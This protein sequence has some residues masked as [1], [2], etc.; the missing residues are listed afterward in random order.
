MSVQGVIR[1]PLHWG[2]GL[3]LW[4]L[5]GS[6]E[7][8]QATYCP[9]STPPVPDHKLEVAIKFSPPFVMGS[10]D[11]PEGLS[12]KLWE[13]IANCLN[14]EAKDYELREYGSVDELLDATENG[15]ADLAVA[16]ITATVE[17]EQKVDFSH[18][19]Y[20]AS[21]GALVAKG[22]D[23]GDFPELAK[24]IL[25]SNLVWV[26]L[27]FAALLLAVAGYYWASEREKGNEI[28]IKG[29][30]KG[31]Y[32]ALIWAFLLVFKGQGNPLE[33]H[34]RL[35]QILN[36]ALITLS[37]TIVSSFTAVIT[38]NLTLQGL[39][40]KIT[41]LDDLRNRSVAT[42]YQSPS[43]DWLEQHGVFARQLQTLPQIQEQLDTGGINVFVH[44][45][46]ILQYM[47]NR[48]DLYDVKLTPL[49]INPQFYSIALPNDSALREY[50]NLS[51]LAITQDPVWETY[52]KRF[53]G[54]GN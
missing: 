4:L 43:S 3:G 5:I 39:E 48:Q 10:I 40:P 50:I 18:N 52:V 16:A 34:T 13:L 20:Q 31:F 1:R 53:L 46:E 17:R 35:G 37:V 38:S 15:D 45:R 23:V 9:D 19:Y 42:L 44:D 41:S 36:L 7:A 32:Q 28:F 21:L 24:R 51:I 26:L 49:S 12:I 30:F 25:S 54:V 27:G 47:V 8:Q 33:L 11:Q 6:V 22:H 14:L 2:L 29:P